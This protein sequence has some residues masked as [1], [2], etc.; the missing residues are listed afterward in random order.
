VIRGSVTAGELVG[1]CAMNGERVGSP[2]NGG[3]SV[4]TVKVGGCAAA[5]SSSDWRTAWSYS[6]RVL[7]SAANLSCSCSLRYC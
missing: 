4:S 3:T 7:C 5:A 6:S 2:D 1:A